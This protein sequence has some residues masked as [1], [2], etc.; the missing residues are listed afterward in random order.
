MSYFSEN[1]HQQF[2]WMGSCTVMPTCSAPAIWSKS[3]HLTEA[4]ASLSASWNAIQCQ[5][6]LWHAH[7]VIQRVRSRTCKAGLF[8]KTGE[9]WCRQRRKW[10]CEN[11]ACEKG[12]EVGC[13]YY[14]CLSKVVLYIFKWCAQVCKLAQVTFY[15]LAPVIVCLDCCNKNTIV[16]V[17]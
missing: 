10:N 2:S 17:A 16:W 3:G 1:L 6:R 7:K 11:A 9:W 4:S 5:I 13:T 8:C 12:E 15:F 14:C